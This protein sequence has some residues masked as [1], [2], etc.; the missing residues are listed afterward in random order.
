[1][2]LGCRGRGHRGPRIARGL[3]L[4]TSDAVAA[5]EA[6]TGRVRHERGC[7]DAGDV[8]H[9]AGRD[10]VRQRSHADRTSFASNASVEEPDPSEA[11]Q[12]TTVRLSGR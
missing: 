7:H 9:H 2:N 1:V 3:H 6:I 10:G 8:S 4:V 5:Q 11:S 12:Q